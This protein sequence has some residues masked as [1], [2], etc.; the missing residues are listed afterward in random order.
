[1]K[2]QIIVDCNNLAYSSFY[3]F[4]DL[5][6]LEKK[7][8]VIF[9]FIQ[10]I[11]SL[12]KK[13]ETTDFIFCWDSKKSYRK[14]IYP[15]YKANR[16]KDLS[17]EERADLNL[18]FSQFTEL[19]EKILP[20]LGFNNVLMQVGYEADD[21][22]AKVVLDNQN[23]EKI[24]VSTDQDLYQ[25]LQYSANI[26]NLRTKKIF[27]WKDFVEK[28]KATPNLWSKVKAIAGCS[29]DNV[30]GI[31]G[32]GEMTAIKYLQDKLQD[33]AVKSRIVSK[34]GREII[35]K[36]MLLVELPFIGR[37]PINVEIVEN[38]LSKEKFIGVFMQ[39]GFESLLKKEAVESWSKGLK[40]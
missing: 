25:L 1:M 31:K 6:Y 29:T 16:K 2:K 27:T 35:S 23:K 20:E 24:I 21:L 8:G 4:K 40:L 22:I 28:Y 32:V 7:T 39:Q 10:K 3:V 11:I 37:K 30:I 13:F 34:E 38:N 19:R 9:G 17:N 26:Y 36:N 18:A 14:L 33:G 15:A 12:A 5:K